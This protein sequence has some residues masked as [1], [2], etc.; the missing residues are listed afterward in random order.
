MFTFLYVLL[1]FVV[2]GGYMMGVPEEKHEG[3]GCGYAMLLGI[4]FG[5]GFL[6]LMWE[7][8]LWKGY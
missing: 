8:I 4:A 1:M 2:V 7:T 6:I 5:L 3:M